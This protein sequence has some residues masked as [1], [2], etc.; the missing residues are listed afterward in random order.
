M[1]RLRQQNVERVPTSATPAKNC[2]TRTS[3]P[4]CRQMQRSSTAMTCKSCL[5]C[6]E[7]ANV[8]STWEQPHYNI[9][10]PCTNLSGPN[11]IW[12][13]AQAEPRQKPHVLLDQ[14]MRH[15]SASG[16]SIHS[17]VRQGL[18][19]M[20]QAVQCCYDAKCCWVY[21]AQMGFDMAVPMSRG[22]MGSLR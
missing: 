1:W 15:D 10:E 5:Q 11:G 9:L 3:N 4:R 17:C 7:S 21:A 22:Q 18:M 19:Q 6:E 13:R 14:T 12:L 16:I 8:C 20:Q 2:A